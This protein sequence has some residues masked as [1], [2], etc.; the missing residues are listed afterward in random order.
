MKKAVGQPCGCAS[1]CASNFC[2]DGFC[3]SDACSGGCR[4]CGQT[5]SEGTCVARSSGADPRSPTDC[6]T[7]AASTC[8]F[9]GKCDGAGACR[10]FVSGTVCKAGACDGDAVTGQLVC[11]GQG[12]CRPG[13]T[14]ICSPF[15]C[16]PSE[17]ACVAMCSGTNQCVAGHACDASGSCGKRLSG[18]HCTK[19]RRL[20]ARASAPTT[21]AA[22]RPARGRASPARSLALG[23]L[24]R[25]FALGAPIRT[26]SA[27]I[28]APPAA[29]QN[30]L[31]DGVG[32]CSL[33]PAET[34]AWPPACSGNRSTRPA[35]CDGLGTCRPPGLQDC[36]PFVCAR[37]APARQLPEA[38]ATATPASAA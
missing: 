29:G 36:S 34:V 28:R 24:L 23:D 35:T 7:A 33:Y 11:D 13:P 27:R 4:T 26:A 17:G 21:S 37:R 2:I 18:A 3:C 14:M 16:D 19:A 10:K 1:D 38:T 25:R 15:S 8:S 5:G 31:C 22:T 30:G 9:D 6:Q 20:P 32:G 12:H